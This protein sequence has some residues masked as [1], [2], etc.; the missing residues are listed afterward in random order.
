MK[1][2]VPT[3]IRSTFFA[4]N[5]FTGQLKKYLKCNIIFLNQHEISDRWSTI[6]PYIE[7]MGLWPDW[8]VGHGLKCPKT[9]SL[10]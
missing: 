9:L 1:F 6:M 10:K 7:Y 4:V 5:Q 8:G 3:E 2:H